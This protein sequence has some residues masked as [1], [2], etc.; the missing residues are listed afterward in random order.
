MHQTGTPPPDNLEPDKITPDKIMPGNRAPG[1]VTPDAQAMLAK[2]GQ[3]GVM[4]GAPPL[5]LSPDTSTTRFILDWRYLQDNYPGL[6]QV[7][8]ATHFELPGLV[9]PP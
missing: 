9:G 6:L 3:P 7:G 1:D 8:L 5:E 4:P 2:T